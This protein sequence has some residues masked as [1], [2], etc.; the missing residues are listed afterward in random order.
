MPQLPLQC[1]VCTKWVDRSRCAVMPVGAAPLCSIC[2]AISEV[3]S[4]QRTS[5]VTRAEEDEVLE[6]LARVY[7][8]LW[9]SQGRSPR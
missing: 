8:V 1:S 2:G 5:S 6:A 7:E 3:Q 9:R 4:A